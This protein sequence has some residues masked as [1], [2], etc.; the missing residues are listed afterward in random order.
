MSS[1]TTR[2]GRTLRSSHEFFRGIDDGVVKSIVQL[3]IGDVLDE[4][5]DA[6]IAMV[7]KDLVS[8]A[9]ARCAGYGNKVLEMDT[10][11]DVLIDSELERLRLRILA[12]SQFQFLRNRLR[13]RVKARALIGRC[14]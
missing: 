9:N 11:E 13:A 14:D 10:E 12:W 1:H 6:C 5:D 7:G 3:R 2:P 8:A 4:R